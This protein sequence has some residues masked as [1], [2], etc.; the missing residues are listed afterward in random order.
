LTPYCDSG[1]PTGSLPPS[2]IPAAK[3]QLVYCN[4]TLNELKA[5]N[6]VSAE[7]PL[8]FTLY[9]DFWYSAFTYVSDRCFNDP[10]WI[11]PK[12]RDKRTMC[13][14]TAKFWKSLYRS[15]DLDAIY[16]SSIWPDLKSRRSQEFFNKTEIARIKAVDEYVRGVKYNESMDEMSANAFA[17]LT[18][19]LPIEKPLAAAVKFGGKVLG[20]GAEV[21][22][23]APIGTVARTSEMFAM[24]G[25]IQAARVAERIKP[26]VTGPLAGLKVSLSKVFAGSKLKVLPVDNLSATN[27]V[28][29]FADSWLAAMNKMAADQEVYDA[30]YTTRQG[31]NRQFEFLINNSYVVNGREMSKLMTGSRTIGSDQICSAYACSAKATGETHYNEDMITFFAHWHGGGVT[32]PAN[33]QIVLHETS[34]HFATWKADGSYSTYFSR[35]LTYNPIEEGAV[36]STAD[37]LAIKFGY[38]PAKWSVYRDEKTW[39][40]EIVSAIDRGKK[41]GKIKAKETGRQLSMSYLYNRGLDKLDEVLVPGLPKGSKVT[42]VLN[43][44]F[45]RFDSNESQSAIDLIKSLYS[46]K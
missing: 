28:D 43:V 27:Y 33:E 21:L 20:V 46:T 2:L 13:N 23:K 45:M 17:L 11:V 1:G 32:N 38:T 16:G 19:A 9:V 15:S 18:F 42:S 41:L 25:S 36:D 6:V 7:T 44:S 12:G 4:L 30:V 37:Y 29:R 34:H 35:S 22:T 3:A 31:L 26:I 39:F 14:N 5:K 8:K 24:K 40:N 10:N